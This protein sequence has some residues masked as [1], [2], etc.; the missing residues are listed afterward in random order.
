MSVHAPARMRAGIAVLALTLLVAG[1]GGADEPS[2]AA[3]TAP[4]PGAF[5][6][7]EAGVKPFVDPPCRA[8]RTAAERDAPGVAKA[9]AELRKLGDKKRFASRYAGLVPCVP[10]E[11]IVVFRVP[12]P[13][14]DF[15]TAARKIARKHRV[16][17]AFADALFTYAQAQ[18]TKRAVLDRFAKLDL[19]GAPFAF[20]RIRENGT[21]E[22]G[23]RANVA[24]AERVVADLLDR[25]FV[26]LVPGAAG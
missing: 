14:K 22:V 1:C 20:V 6:A 11:R 12:I 25:V 2:A 9:A 7:G 15:T 24:G 13:G 3:T 8:P 23:V 17:V 26:V 10:T 18:A 19:A 5:V 21:A 16:E 4:S